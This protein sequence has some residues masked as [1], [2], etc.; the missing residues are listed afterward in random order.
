M[1]DQVDAPREEEVTAALEWV[2][3][4]AEDENEHGKR[5]AQVIRAALSASSA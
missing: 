4:V 5:Y 2:E 3:L 1:S